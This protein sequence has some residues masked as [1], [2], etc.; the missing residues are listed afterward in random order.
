MAS[1]IALGFMFFSGSVGSYFLGI[2]ADNTGLA[3]ALQGTAA[4]PLFAALTA[5]LL[6]QPNHETYSTHPE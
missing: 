2:V 4:L 5:L 3:A 6:P 1:G